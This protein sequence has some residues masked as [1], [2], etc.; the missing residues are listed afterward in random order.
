M[1][2][3]AAGPKKRKIWKVLLWAVVCGVILLGAVGWY[4]TTALFQNWLRQRVISE[5]ERVTGGRVEIGSLHTV[6]FRLRVIIR[7]LTIHGL[8]APTEIPLFHAEQLTATARIIS[9][10]GAE[11][12]LEAL[13]AERPVI[14]LLVNPDGS[15]NIPGPRTQNKN[16]IQQLFELSIGKL[17]VAGGEVIYGDERI[18]LDFTAHDVNA[19]MNFGVLRRR[20]HANISVGKSDTV[21]ASYRPF[22]WSGGARFTLSRQGANIHELRLTSAGST[23]EAKGNLED[24]S[25]PRMSLDYNLKLDLADAAAIL[26]RPEVRHGTLQANGKGLWSADN[27]SSLGKLIIKD[28][29][30]R[31]APVGLRNANLDTDFSIDPTKLT[32]S[33]IR[34][35]LMRG[36]ATGDAAVNNWQ[37]LAYASVENKK[38]RAAKRDGSSGNLNLK[39]KDVSIEEVAAAASTSLRPFHRLQLAGF[40]KGTLD[41]SWKEG[42]RNSEV[43]FLSDVSPP[44]SVSPTQMPVSA[45]ATGIYRLGP[46]ELQLNELHAATR[47]T[48]VQASGTLSRTARMNFSVTTSNLA[49]WQPVLDAVG[50]SHIPI[51]LRGP[52]TF[53]GSAN[54]RLSEIDFKG[55][56]QSEDF[57]VIVPALDHQ[58]REIEWDSLAGQVEISPHQFSFR[59]GTLR[60]GNTAVAFD[61]SAALQNRQFTDFT[62]LTGNVS[63]VNA[64]VADTLALAGLNY[65]ATGTFDLTLRVSGTPAQPHGAGH[66]ELHKGTIYGR[67][68]DSFSSDLVLIGSAIQLNNLAFALNGGKIEGAGTYDLGSEAIQLNV[69]GTGFELANIPDL[70]RTRVSIEGKMN[71]QANASGTL[72]EPVV[73]AAIH[74]SG[75]SFDHEL[76]GDFD[77]NA[78]THGSDLKLSGKSQF[79]QADL[80]IDGN[81]SLRSDCPANLSLHFNHLDVD[82]LLR[83][84]LRGRVT[85]HSATAG[86]ITLSGPLRQPR[87]LKASGTIS[88]VMIDVENI[89]LRNDGPIRFSA[90]REAVNIDRLRLVGEA[91]DL[92]AGGTVSLVEDQS[93]DLKAKG[94]VNLKLIESFN[95]DFTSAGLVSVDMGIYGTLAKPMTQGRVYVQNGSIAYSELPSA[96]SDINGSLFFNQ[97]RLQI[98]TLNAH[99]GGGAVSFSGFATYYQKQLNFDLSLHGQGV[100]LRYPPGI[101]STADADLRFTGTPAESTLSGDITVNKLAITPGFDFG[102]YL[103][104]SAQISAL[105]PT[106]PVLNRIR[107]DVHVVTVPELQMQTASIRL[108]GD[109]DLRLRGTAAKPVIVGRAD[110]IEGEVFFNGTKYRLERGDVSF[111]NPVVTTPILDLQATTRV[112]DYDISLNLNGPVDRPSVTYRS[113]PPLPTSDI[114]ALLAF[115]QTTEQSAQLQGSGNGLGLE[116]GASSAILNAALNATVSSRVQR[117]FGVSRIKIDPQG[118]VT[119]TSPTQ[120]GPAVTVE[121]QVKNDLTITYTTNVA[122]ASQQIIQVEY[123]ISRNVS[124]VGLRDQNGVVS[125]DV[126]IRKRKK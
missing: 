93:L 17:Q 65:P 99:T 118:L 4:A 112:R 1:T 24:F 30:W 52:A 76:A 87:Q 96:L 25:R 84:Y 126:R 2:E 66:V 104:S 75:L 122:Q 89:K 49:D 72:S 61:L 14:H 20:F 22:S 83:S 28:L 113:E 125:F 120:T 56:L 55:S 50:Y 57:S 15:T 44:S 47:A 40:S 12:G 105:P 43:R 33:R 124:I 95:S 77:L 19:E 62:P 73:N 91:T 58:T 45:H 116:A 90:S 115:G 11:F 70:Q 106:N 13:E 119:E 100:R 5:L 68:I 74:A 108:S 51:T 38:D 123:N 34:A 23:F 71:F 81:V 111:I 117:L 88:D 31:E 6:P 42:V 67:S 36:L 114:I 54:G 10:T 7:G 29:E 86:D 39:F 79:K 107:M 8:E 63:M 48:Q 21:L 110:V 9:L 26:R 98:E 121:Q 103:A 46:G 59:H 18:P 92:T 32:L 80:K 60:H 101:S 69:Q 27:F 102:R 82:A 109:A 94:S 3:P 85:G 97:D 37:E 35:Q 64:D 53:T 78:I 16:P 41:V